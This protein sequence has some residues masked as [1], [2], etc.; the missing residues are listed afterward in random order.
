MDTLGEQL[1]DLRTSQDL[2][3]DDLNSLK[4]EEVLA[5]AQKI[6]D[7]NAI[8]DARMLQELVDKTL[9]GRKPHI[10]QQDVRE[11]VSN[12]LPHRLSEEDVLRLIRQHGGAPI[13]QREVVF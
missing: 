5:L 6:L 10:T 13:S 11:I 2:L 3:N 9:D 12:Q 4:D 7:E 8:R 1:A